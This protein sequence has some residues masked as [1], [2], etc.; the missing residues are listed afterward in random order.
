MPAEHSRPNFF[1]ILGLDPNAPWDERGYV[2][3]LDEKKREWSGQRSGVKT[4]PAT[5]Q[6][7]RNL[8]LVRDIE[9]VMR[10]DASR[11]VERQAAIKL[12]VEENRERADNVARRVELM[13][14]KGFLYEA[15]YEAVKGDLGAA[16]EAVRRRVEAAERRPDPDAPGLAGNERLDQ[17]T[18]RNLRDSLRTVGKADLYEVLREVAPHVGSASPRADL[19]GA[20]DKLYQKARHTANKDTPE[21]SARQV[22]AGIARTVF[23][24]DESRR[25]YEFSM[26]LA[27]LDAML[28][29]YRQ[30]L[31]PARAIDARQAEMFLREA[32]E[33]GIEVG[34]AKEVFIAYFRRLK[35]VVEIPGA[36]AE[37]TLKTLGSCPRCAELNDPA[38]RHCVKCGSV[39]MS[40]CPRCGIELLAGAGACPQCGLHVGLH[41]Y[42]EYLADEAEGFLT[43][44]DA[45]GADDSLRQANREWPLGPDSQDPLAIRLRQL[46]ERLGPVQE[47]QRRVIGQIGALMD[48]RSYR[49]ARRQLREL[50]F[51]SAAAS[52]MLESCE[53]AI[54]ES[55]LRVAQARRPGIPEERKAALLL[56]ALRHC[57]DNTE[58]SRELSML[59]PSPPR[60]LRAESDEERCVV[61]LT[62]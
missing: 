53:N 56:E 4:Q 55:D 61:R 38:A 41:D 15:E 44:G 58:A 2:R 24:T 54:R 60:G 57:A 37:A 12:A 20:A 32:V 23:G 31:A 6:A 26:R 36:A 59:P 43:R 19:L 42:V 5:V 45:D 14:A 40:R 30:D 13:L 7:R 16:D 18:E 49:S 39:L 17:A 11:D 50:P 25:R 22:L 10:H 34:L 48:S 28:E 62:W 46:A 9:R 51:R 8:S 21:V 27:P 3:A 52:A 1:L 35:W 29:R 33:S 47:S